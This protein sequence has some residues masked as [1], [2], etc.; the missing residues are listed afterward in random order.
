MR[1]DEEDSPGGRKSYNCGCARRK[2]WMRQEAT[3]GKITNVMTEKLKGPLNQPTNC[4]TDKNI[5]LTDKNSGPTDIFLSVWV[6]FLSVSQ[7]FRPKKHDKPPNP[8]NLPTYFRCIVY[9][10]YFLLPP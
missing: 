10:T 3:N 9:P 8:V 1:R 6:T 5:G 2:S 7:I 4:P